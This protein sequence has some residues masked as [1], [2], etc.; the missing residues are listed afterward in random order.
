MDTVANVRIHGETGQKPIERFEPE[1][2]Q[3]K[4]LPVM[5]YDCAVIR[6]T[7][8]NRCCHVRFQTNRYSVPSVCLPATDPEGLPGPVA[9]LPCRE[10]HRHSPPFL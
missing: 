7:P 8:A 4:P 9:L 2:P 3:L 5:P 10:A 1:K 6:Q